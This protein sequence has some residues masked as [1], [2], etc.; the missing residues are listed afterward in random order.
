MKT[1]RTEDDHET[2]WAEIESI[3][4]Y[5]LKRERMTRVLSKGIRVS[6]E[7][8]LW[9]EMERRARQGGVGSVKRQMN[10][11]ETKQGRVRA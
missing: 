3:K 8:I 2:K 10:D 11:R 5:E 1:E 6:L 9:Y 4:D 7:T